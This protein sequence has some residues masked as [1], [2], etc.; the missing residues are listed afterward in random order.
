MQTFRM[1]KWG[2]EKRKFQA[3]DSKVSTQAKP[4]DGDEDESLNKVDF[5]LY[6]P[7]WIDFKDIDKD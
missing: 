4:R 1:I 6:S 5:T 3:K 2:W 7:L